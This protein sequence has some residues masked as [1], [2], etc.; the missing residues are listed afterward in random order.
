MGELCLT[1]CNFEILNRPAPN[2][3]QIDVISF[4]TLTRNLFESTL[5]NTLVPSSE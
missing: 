4:L 3:A 1:A 2:L 5:E